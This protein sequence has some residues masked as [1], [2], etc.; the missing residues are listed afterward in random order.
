M[1][2]ILKTLK[3]ERGLTLLEI[4]VTLIIAALLGSMLIEYMGTSLTR[5]GESVVMVQKG[6]SLNSVM[7][8]ITA[9]YEDDYKTGS[10]DFDTF[11]TNIENGN[12]DTNTPYYGDYTVVTEYI[13]FSGNN[14]AAD[15]GS[16]GYNILKVTITADNQSLTVL[17]RK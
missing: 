5:S 15:D 14:E 1:K 12:I 11:K 13:I 16:G 6:F 4:I 2:K 7:E 17:F 9:D 8:K 10:Y 3:A